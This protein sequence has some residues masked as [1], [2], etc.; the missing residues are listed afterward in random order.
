VCPLLQE[1]ENVFFMILEDRTASLKQAEELYAA[2][3]EFENLLKAIL[4]S[5]FLERYLAGG[6][7]LT[8][9]ESATLVA[10]QIQATDES[11]IDYGLVVVDLSDLFFGAFDRRLKRIRGSAKIRQVN[12]CYWAVFG[13]FGSGVD[14]VCEAYEFVKS[15]YAVFVKRDPSNI[16]WRIRVCIYAL[17]ECDVGMLSRRRLQ[18]D[19]FSEE[20]ILCD[21][22]LMRCI[23]RHAILNEHVKDALIGEVLPIREFEVTQEFKTYVMDLS[24]LSLNCSAFSFTPQSA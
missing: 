3:Q 1:N 10:I 9:V 11:G 21:Y 20:K 13:A 6:E 14:H 15:C 4:P 17:P 24:H 12:G 18:F 19:V 22:M 5:D 16:A 23:D 7:L 8:H 2:D